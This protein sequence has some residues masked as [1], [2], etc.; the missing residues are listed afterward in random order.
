[1]SDQCGVFDVN[2]LLSAL[3]NENNE[4]FMTMNKEKIQ[5][6]KND[7]LQQLQ[8]Q[9]NILKQYH[10]KL[11]QYRYVDDL[12]D[13][14]YGCYI[15]WINLTNPDNLNLTNGGLIVDINFYDDGVQ[16]KCKNNYN[17]FFNIKFDES[18]IFQKLSQQE[19][20]LLQIM[21]ALDK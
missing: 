5:K 11:K 21:E 13:L 3:D 18:M 7:M 10:K 4:R 16:I 17:R 15:R 1:M 6:I 12:A 9:S 8:L 14:K 19:L 20:I 2:K